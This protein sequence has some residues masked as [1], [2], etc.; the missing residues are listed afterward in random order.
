MRQPIYLDILFLLNML[1]T[2]LLLSAASHLA[3]VRTKRWRMILA[4]LLGGVFSLLI[5]VRL[6]PFESFFVNLTT[7][8]ALCAAVFWQKGKVRIFF[9]CAAC[10]FFASFLF[11]GFMTAVWLFFPAQGMVYRNGV[12]Y[13]KISAFTLAATSTAAYL[14]IKLVCRILNR[15]AGKRMIR[16]IEITLRQQSVALTALVDT[17][18]RLC[19]LFSGLPV[20]VASYESVKALIPKSLQVYFSSGIPPDLSELPAEELRMIR[21][22]PVKTVAGEQLL[23]SFLPDRITVEGEERRAVLAV[24]KNAVSD[25]AYEAILNPSLT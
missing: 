7:G 13:F 25:G 24:C 4:V 1:V 6:N 2:F 18:N 3:A 11:A 14:M 10:F 12:L 16:R 19:D 8:F 21:M 15:R 22:L 20:V 9:K 5:F 23:P 17:G